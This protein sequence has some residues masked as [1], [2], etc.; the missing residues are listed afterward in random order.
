MSFDDQTEIVQSA[1]NAGH[2]DGQGDCFHISGTIT[3][4]RGRKVK[5]AT[6][7]QGAAAPGVATLCAP[8]STDVEITA[9]SIIAGNDPAAGSL[10]H[11][12][13]IWLQKG[14]GGAVVHRCDISGNGSMCAI[15]CY[16][17]TGVL[18]DSNTIHD[19]YWSGASAHERVIGVYLFRSARAVVTN[20]T[21]LKLGST[22]GRWH[23]TDGIT[24]SACQWAR[25]VGNYIERTGEGIDLTGSFGNCRC[26]VA[27]NIVHMPDS[28]GIK[29][30][31]SAQQVH[32]DGNIVRDAG[33]GAYVISGQSEAGNPIRC[34]E[35]YLTNNQAI[36]T[37]RDTN[38][39][40]QY[41]AGLRIMEGPQQPGYP[42]RN[43][44]DG[45]VAR[46]AY[47]NAVAHTQTPGNTIR[48]AF[49]SASDGTCKI[50]G[51]W[52]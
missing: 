41:I 39:A 14:A 8:D 36:D 20:N 51:S 17:A 22:S 35:N 9:V 16:D 38:W 25:V 49:G 5:N 37:G 42:T 47:Q 52:L 40:G 12:S 6:I 1:I 34:E 23:E 26:I 43:I 30:A 32:V 3:V 15:R 18:V 24:L 45:F 4:P 19:I 46:S 2:F 13:A 27:Q 21:I 31:N 44:I 11:S 33:F 48:N 29:L 50:E 28:W 10:A 7:V